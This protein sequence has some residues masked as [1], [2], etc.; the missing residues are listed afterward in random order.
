MTL[1]GMV[2]E[3]GSLA[4]VVVTP[5][6]EFTKPL[7]RAA[8]AGPYCGLAKGLGTASTQLISSAERRANVCMIGKVFWEDDMSNAECL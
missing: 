8:D 3:A 7:D 6:V 4:M 1:L 5:T 2:L